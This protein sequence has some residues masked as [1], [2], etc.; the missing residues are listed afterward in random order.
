M[1]YLSDVSVRVSLDT[2]ELQRG[3][4]DVR[5]S[6]EGLTSSLK[7]IGGI[8]AGAFALG[9]IK[10]FGVGCLK[11]A[12]DVEEME[13][14]FNV[15]FKSTGKDIDQWAK[16]FGNAIGRNKN[17]IKGAVSNM[18][19]LLTG[20]GMSEKGAGDLSK[21]VVTLGY[22]LASFNN[23]QD[24]EA[25]IAMQS[26]LLGEHD[27]AKKLGIAINDA[28]I[29]EAMHQMGIKD[30][31]QTLDEAT[32]AQVRYKVMT[33]QTANAQGDAI[34]SADGYANT[35]KA[36]KARM[37][38]IQE[39]IGKVLLPIAKKLLDTFTNVGIPALERLAEGFKNVVDF[40]KQ[41]NQFFKTNQTVLTAAGIVI[42]ALGVAM[43]LFAIQL[44]W[45]A[46]TTAVFTKVTAIATAVTGGFAT[47]MAVLTSPITLVILAIGALIAIGYL[48]VKNWDTVKS[49]MLGVWDKIASACKTAWNWIYNSVIKPIINLV[50]AYIKFWLTVV[51]TIV[52]AVKTVFKTAW[53]WIYNSVIKPVINAI[54][55]TIGNIS[56]KV[57]AVLNNVRSVF[58]STWGGVSSIVSNVVSGITS[59][60]SSIWSTASNIAGK[61]KS[62]FSNLF[63]GI[64][65]PRFS[66]TGS[67]N[68]TNWASQGLPK[69]NVQWNAS[70]GI[71]DNTTLIG[72]GEA[73]AEGI[74]PL[75]NRRK[76]A[77]FA[78][79]VARYMPSNGG[80]NLTV[81]VESLVV[82]EKA[83]INKVAEQLYRLQKREQRAKGGT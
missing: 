82:R 45:V 6:T 13:N 34:R 12:S 79:A 40:V 76:M 25:I 51:T 65:V 23:L 77:P 71:L 48:L 4:A 38:E 58:S 31:W 14:K 24:E 62:A 63:S 49:F 18:G 74:V 37:E 53:N 55:S 9:K 80:G 22:D 35:L 39:G 2:G 21:S 57:M 75:Q 72:A 5:G 26:A 3:M 10:D 33:N 28:T 8:L 69:L 41:T 32:K 59:K 1:A 73:G 43:A 66:M 7:K 64:K 67:L 81:N 36:V 47:A 83:D 20:F 16:G 11:M 56:N 78:Q 42:T 29:A 68:P 54:S 50:I 70:G 27:A 30:K 44:K 61:I 17:E 52:N 46:I 19:D 60:I 15:V